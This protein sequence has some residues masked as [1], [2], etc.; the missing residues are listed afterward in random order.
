MLTV[1]VYDASPDREVPQLGQESTNPCKRLTAHLTVIDGLRGMQQQMPYRRDGAVDQFDEG[2]QLARK[3]LYSLPVD[4]FEVE[5][6]IHHR[7]AGQQV[8]DSA[9]R[10]MR[11][12]GVQ[13]VLHG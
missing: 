3:M 5:R 10:V 9:H 4:R 13:R 11:L 1:R 6:A 8:Q 2:V 7:Q 12:W